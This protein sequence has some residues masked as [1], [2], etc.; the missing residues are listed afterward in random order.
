M[1]DTTRF[2]YEKFLYRLEHKD[3]KTT[4]VCYF[5]CQEHLDKYLTRHKLKKKDVKVE[6]KK[7]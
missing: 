3:L 6:K 7:G 5:E 1:I 4:K 2:P